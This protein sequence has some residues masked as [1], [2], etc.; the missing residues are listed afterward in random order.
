M[1]LSASLKAVLAEVV[2]ERPILW[3]APLASW[4]TYRIGGPADAL[5]TL[6]DGAEVRQL[7]ALCRREGIRWKVLGRGSNILASDDGFRGLIIVLEGKFKYIVRQQEAVENRPVVQ[8]GA[9]VSLPRLADWC[10]TEGCGGLE[11]TAGI[12]GTVAGAVIMNAG[13]WGAEMSRIVGEVELLG[14]DGSVALKAAQLRFGYRCCLSLREE[15][16]DLV[17]G[18]V[19]IILEKDQP[20]GIRKRMRELQQKRRISQPVGLASGGCVFKNPAG[21]SAGRLIDE[22]GLK[23]MR[24]GDAQI[25]ETHANFFVNRGRASAADMLAL[26]RLVRDRVQETSG[27]ILEMEIEFLPAEPSR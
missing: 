26:I 16:G 21:V 6:H 20:E 25:S 11:F 7:L 14:P 22:A 12:P 2:G 13:A 10:C 18:K 9:A 24:I 17:I 19:Q 1:S 27:N 4:T 23:G 8:V 15:F 3:E 5:V